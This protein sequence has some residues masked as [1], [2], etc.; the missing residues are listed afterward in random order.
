MFKILILFVYFNRPNILPNILSSIL[1]NDY[2]NWLLVFGDDG[3]DV[4]GEPIA[5][6]VLKDHLDKVIFLNS[7]MSI[8]DKMQYG[9]RTGTYINTILENLD[10]D[11]WTTWTD[12]DKLHKDYLAN[13]NRFFSESDAKYCYSDT[14]FYNPYLGTYDDFDKRWV[15][16]LWKGEG[17]GGPQNCL[18]HK[19][20]GCQAAFRRE[21]FTKYGARYC[22]TTKLN[23]DYPVKLNVDG[24]FFKSLEKC[25]VPPAVYTGFVSQYKG[26]HDYQLN[27]HK[28][29]NFRQKEDI[30]SY[31]DLNLVAK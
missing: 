29:F 21:C 25:G 19:V 26:I 22:E 18:Y 3:S 9:L 15:K 2:N 23:D 8:E 6:E 24:E 5:R 1:E 17:Y 27:L 14:I 4:P 31:S 16:S 11:I 13:L 30:K 12:D 10:Y 7:H 20:D 28:E